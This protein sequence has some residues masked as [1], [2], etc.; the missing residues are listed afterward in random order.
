MVWPV[1]MVAAEGRGQ[2]NQRKSEQ[3]QSA[4]CWGS[5]CK[6]CGIHS[7]SRQLMVVAGELHIFIVRESFLPPDYERNLKRILKSVKTAG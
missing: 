2:K 1:V 4:E 3:G 5:F 7:L 6:W